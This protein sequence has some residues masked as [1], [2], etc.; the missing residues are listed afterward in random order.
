MEVGLTRKR[1]ILQM[2]GLFFSK[3]TPQIFFLLWAP[4]VTTKDLLMI[5]FEKPFEL[6][7][8]E[9]ITHMA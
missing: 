1:E 8:K 3:K 9:H 6:F 5:K 2:S 4:T 7:V